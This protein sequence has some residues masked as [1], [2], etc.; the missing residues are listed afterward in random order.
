MRSKNNNRLP[1]IRMP[2]KKN[3]RTPKEPKSQEPSEEIDLEAPTQMV[4]IM[5]YVFIV[6]GII[7]LIG[8][9]DMTFSDSY[10]VG[11]SPAGRTS[12]GGTGSING[13]TAFFF[14]FALLSIPLFRYIKKRLQRKH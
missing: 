4:K 10:S 11:W 3:P 2:A 9:M 8:G 5:D 13:P 6:C 12:S 1:N 14:G 7:T